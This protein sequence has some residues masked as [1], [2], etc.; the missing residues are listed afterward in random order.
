MRLDGKENDTTTACQKLERYKRAQRRH[1]LGLS[2]GSSERRNDADEQRQQPQG[3]EEENRGLKV[4]VA[5]LR[6]ELASLTAEVKLLTA[7]VETQRLENSVLQKEVQL[8]KDRPMS[9]NF[10]RDCDKRT[11]FFTGFTTFFLFTTVFEF[12]APQV[13]K[14]G[15]LTLMDEFLMV[16][17]KLRLSL[18][19]EDLSYRFGVSVSTVSRIFHKWLEVMYIRLKSCIRW[20]DKETVRKTLPTAFKKHYSKVRCIIDCSEIFIERPT[21]LQARAKTFSNYKK[22]NTVKFLIA[23]T[24]SRTISFVSKCWGGRVS[25]KELTQQSGFLDKLEPTDEVMADRGFLIEEEVALRRAKLIIPA[26][27][28]GKQQLSQKEVEFTRQIANVRIHVE[29]IIGLLKN[30]YSILQSRLPITLIKRKGDT[31]FATV[32]K[33]LFVCAALT[34]FGEPVV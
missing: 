34:N 18:L 2:N 25:D 11:K 17:M 28:K 10:I 22:H 27:T 31:D 13:Q 12:V 32:D 19:N 14:V 29:R 30:R 23:I 9:I 4:Q 8:L 24:P 5:S 1:I 6:A 26:F 16:L 21:S 7:D 3:V 15:K 20:P 33:L